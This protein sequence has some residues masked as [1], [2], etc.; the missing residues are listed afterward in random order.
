M[1]THNAEENTEID[2]RI[3]SKRAML[4]L[5][6]SELPKGVK[7]AIQ[8]LCRQF[9]TCLLSKEKDNHT[10]A[11]GESSDRDYCAHLVQFLRYEY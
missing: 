11:H 6:K 5:E 2:Q 3:R 7:T 8:N 1:A 9:R 4:V 10:I